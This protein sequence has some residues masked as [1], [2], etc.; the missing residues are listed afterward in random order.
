MLLKLYV[1]GYSDAGKK[2]SEKTDCQGLCTYKGPAL[3]LGESVTGTCQVDNQ[4]CGY[5]FWV[6]KGKLSG[7]LCAD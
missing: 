4:P 5:R 3:P 7:D 6:E 1:Y 2:C